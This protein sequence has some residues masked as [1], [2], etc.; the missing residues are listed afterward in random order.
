[1]EH[2]LDSIVTP[3]VRRTALVLLFDHLALALNP[4]A[5]L[6]QSELP[7][8][9]HSAIARGCAFRYVEFETG[10][11]EPKGLA[12]CSNIRLLER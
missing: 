6:V 5:G 2:K 11:V 7:S 3:E 10:P 9:E 4:H 1:M 12:N 8:I